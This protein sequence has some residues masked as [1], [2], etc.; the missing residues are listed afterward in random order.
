MSHYF[1]VVVLGPELAGALAAGLLARRGFRVLV[2]RGESEDILAP[3]GY[4]FCRRPTPILG[5]DGPAWRRVL[6]EL[7]LAQSLRRRLLAQRPPFQVVLPEH[8]L[9]GDA[10]HAGAEIERELPGAREAFDGLFARAEALAKVLEPLFAQDVTLPPDGFWERR[11]LARIKP[12]LPGPQEDLL[13]SLAPGADARA[14]AHAPAALLGDLY[15]PSPVGVLRLSELLRRGSFRLPGGREALHK[16]LCER[17]QT[18]SGELAEQ[19]IAEIAVRRGRVAGVVTKRGETIGCGF[20][21]A[22]MTTER[23]QAWLGEDETPRRLAAAARAVKPVLWRHV[24]H[25]VVSAE[26]IPEGMAENVFVVADP[27][28]PLEE[29][30]AFAVHLADTHEAG[31]AALSVVALARS[32]E[33]SYLQA[34]GHKVRARLGDLLVPFLDR[35]LVAAWVPCESEGQPPPEPVYG[36]DDLGPLGVGATP[37]ATGVRNLYLLG[38]QTL[39]GLGTEGELVAAWGAARLISLAEKKRDPLKREILLSRS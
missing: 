24:S 38:R 37:I 19:A 18:H 30:N 13:P 35:H 39:P 6:H 9:D 21:L 1:D 25:L 31:R 33:P 15:P 36:A 4:T 12:H 20:I 11:E 26:G 14:F 22:A 8:R 23:L 27:A 2:A 7:N 28:R 32:C 34:L 17:I 29:D 3:E 16:L 5:I 10:E